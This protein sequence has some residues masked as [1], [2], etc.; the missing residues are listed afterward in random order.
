MSV[1]YSTRCPTCAFD[2]SE[3]FYMFVVEKISLEI[4]ENDLTQ[5]CCRIAFRGQFNC[6][7]IKGIPSN[8]SIIRK[9]TTTN[10][11]S[12]EKSTFQ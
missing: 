2:L 6:T 3:Y 1:M 12:I 4:I 8:P 5:S 7:K 9:S 10:V 11:S